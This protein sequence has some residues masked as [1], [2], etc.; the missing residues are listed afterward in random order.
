M[1]SNGITFQDLPVTMLRQVEIDVLVE[2]KPNPVG[3]LP[4][5]MLKRGGVMEFMLCHLQEETAIRSR[6]IPP[7]TSLQDSD[8]AATSR[9][10]SSLITS[11]G[12][13]NGKM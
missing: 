3:S 2:D 11:A 8:C 5:G 10:L 7:I 6:A 12:L 9:K 13:Y 4:V 1:L